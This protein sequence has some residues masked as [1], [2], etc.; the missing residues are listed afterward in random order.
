MIGQRLHF[1]GSER[2]QRHE[3]SRAG[4]RA[5]VEAL[6]FLTFVRFRTEGGLR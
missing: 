1:H 4:V 2:A 5:R 3:V 6:T